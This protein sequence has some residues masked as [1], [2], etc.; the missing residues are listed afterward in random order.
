MGGPSSRTCGSRWRRKGTHIDRRAHRPRIA[1]QRAHV[2]DRG[3]FGIRPEPA[4]AIARRCGGQTRRAPWGGRMWRGQCDGS[5]LSKTDGARGSQHFGMC[6]GAPN[7]G[8]VGE[9][10]NST[11]SGHSACRLEDSSRGESQYFS[12]EAHPF[13][14]RVPL[15][16]RE[17]FRA[18]LVRLE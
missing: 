4:A 11:L 1:A 2:D 13:T 8:V 12:E 5:Y 15:G 9:R 18:P 10:L 17:Q 7:C 6:Q 14:T 16:A 3:A